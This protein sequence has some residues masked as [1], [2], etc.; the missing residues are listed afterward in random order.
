MPG[1]TDL[2][3]FNCSLARALN[4]VGDWWTLL[5]IRDAFLGA[6]RF[7]EFQ[8][9][10]GMARNTLSDRLDRLCAA[11]VLLRGGTPAR[12]LY[13]LT[14]KGRALAPA[15]VALQ[16]WGDQFASENRPPV[17]VTDQRGRPLPR[18]KLVDGDGAEVGPR[19]LRFR[20]GP[21]ADARTRARFQAMKQPQKVSE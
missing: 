1:K 10:L 13:C 19:D 17:V 4:D 8:R 3:T 14:E 20:P 5:I 11:G 21:G 9:S 2:A 16:Q 6:Q 7:S 15:L 12:P 18:V